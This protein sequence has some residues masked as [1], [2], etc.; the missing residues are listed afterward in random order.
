MNQDDR[1]II[2]IAALLTGDD[3]EVGRPMPSGYDVYNVPYD[4]R[5]RYYDRPRLITAIVTVMSIKLI[6][7]RS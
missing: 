5:N 1:A 4:Y 7:K 3:F 2:G 6:R